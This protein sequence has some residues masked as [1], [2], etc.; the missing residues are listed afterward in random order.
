MN[1]LIFLALA[2]PLAIVT[3]PPADGQSCM[4][5]Y[6]WPCSDG[7]HSDACGNW[8]EYPI[9]YSSYT[10]SRV[11]FCSANYGECGGDSGGTCD[12]RSIEL[13]FKRCG[14]FFQI[15]R[16]TRCCESNDFARRDK[17][18]QELAATDCKTQPSVSPNLPLLIP[19]D[20]R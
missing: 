1:R 3:V 12:Y 11:S 6:W 14:G 2:I 7:C 15:I 17:K 16:T 9:G 20:V 4:I 10:S 13:Q 5:Q 18:P 19:K 8:L